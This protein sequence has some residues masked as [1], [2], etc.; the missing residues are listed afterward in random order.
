MIKNWIS[1]NEKLHV[2]GDVK[3][4][5]NIIYNKIYQL[6]PNL[7]IKKEITIKNLLQD[8]Y[9]RIKFKD[10]IIKIKIGSNHG[11]I[12]NMRLNN[13]V[14]DNLNMELKISL[15]KEELKN[16]YLIKNRIKE[17]I[18]HESQHIIEFYHTGGLVPSS[19]DFN[20]RLKKHENMFIGYC[21][22]Q[23]INTD[24]WLNITHMFYLCEEH[25]IRS[26]VSS[27]HEYFKNNDYANV[28]DVIKKRK[29][30]KDYKL[31]SS[32]NP[33]LILSNMYRI[34]PFFNS[35]LDD[36]IKNV[37]LNQNS[38][39]DSVFNKEFNLVKKRA[40]NC[41]RNMLSISVNFHIDES[42]RNLIDSKAM[43]RDIKLNIL[44]DTDYKKINEI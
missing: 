41:C 35:V 39:L 11:A 23:N 7:I 6:V 30:F 24:Y 28:E 5:T 42:D 34:Y 43:N 15:S 4:L 16:K 31:I 36:F 20:K 22:T 13:G 10:D 32:E 17:T 1:F 27:T 26:N 21:T 37:I 40:L 25:E 14:I 33:K 9:S 8:N 29:E 2:N 44:L 18:N 3:H 12:K 38:D 19:W